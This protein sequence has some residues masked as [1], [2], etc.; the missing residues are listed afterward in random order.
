MDHADG[1]KVR[2]HFQLTA[3]AFAAA[4]Q[5]LNDLIVSQQQGKS[6]E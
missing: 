4:K 5:A 6:H 1:V 2:Q 3:P